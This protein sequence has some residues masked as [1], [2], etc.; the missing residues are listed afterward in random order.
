M[1]SSLG[2]IFSSVDVFFSW[3]DLFIRERVNVHTHTRVQAVGEAQREKER[4]NPKL[5]PHSARSLS[6]T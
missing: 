2:H 4:E 3:R 1:S 6:G 5:I